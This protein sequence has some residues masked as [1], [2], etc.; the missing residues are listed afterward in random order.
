MR[1]FVRNAVL[2]TLLFLPA[3]HSVALPNC[4]Y[5]QLHCGVTCRYQQGWGGSCSGPTASRESYC[6]QE[7]LQSDYGSWWPS[8]HQGAYDVCCG[9][10]APN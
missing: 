1:G 8:C 7:L 5:H 4:N 6:W 3:K 9:E 10:I 2:F